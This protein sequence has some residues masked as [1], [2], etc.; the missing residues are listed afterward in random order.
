MVLQPVFISGFAEVTLGRQAGNGRHRSAFTGAHLRF[1]IPGLAALSNVRLPYMTGA[2]P[3]QPLEILRTVFGFDG[4]RGD[5]AEI[6]D[7]IRPRADL[8]SL[9]ACSTQ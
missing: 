5:Q 7:R 4:F 8:P 1:Q 6:P 9:L 3:R 2:M